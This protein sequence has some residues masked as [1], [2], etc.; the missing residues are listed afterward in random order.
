MSSKSTIEEVVPNKTKEEPVKKSRT[1]KPTIILEKSY[2]GICEELEIGIDEAGRGPMLGRVYSA[3]VVLPMDDKDF[4]YDWMKDS[5]KFTS[6]KKIVEVAE[7]IKKNAI[8]WSVAYETEEVIDNIN[9]RNATYSAM[10]KAIRET[11][12]SDSKQSYFLLVDGNDFK[13][14][15][16]YTEEDGFKQIPHTCITGGDNKYAAIAAASILAKVSRDEYIEEL[17]E[18]E[19]QLVERY[20]LLKNKG[21]G[22]AKHMEGI[23]N[24]GISK[25]HRKSFGICRQ[26]S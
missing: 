17:C 25:Y 23:K 13:P 15:I 19:P 18:K 12:T 11:I 21:Y 3:A 1:R 10:H 5:K 8:A 4:R 20:D 22:T 9:I 2:R 26:Y 16:N 24:Y 14:V 7:Y 6:K